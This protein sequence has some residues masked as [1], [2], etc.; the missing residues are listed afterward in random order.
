MRFELRIIDRVA[1][2]GKGNRGKQAGARRFRTLVPLDNRGQGSLSD[3]VCDSICGPS[4]DSV[5]GT[6]HRLSLS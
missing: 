2:Y 3:Q 5:Q 6:T 1:V 4:F